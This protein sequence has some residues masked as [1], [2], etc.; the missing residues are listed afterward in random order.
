MWLNAWAEAVCDA[1]TPEVTL[2]L[3]QAR[4]NGTVSGDGGAEEC[5]VVATGRSGGA[6]VAG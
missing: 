4:V 3:S 2:W 1:H 5:R 6:V